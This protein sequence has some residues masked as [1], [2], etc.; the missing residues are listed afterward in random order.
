M[1]MKRILQALDGAATKPVAGSKDMKRFLEIV[2]SSPVKTESEPL[3]E[4]ANPHKVSLPVQ[5]AMQHYQSA[6]VKTEANKHIK[7]S[8]KKFFREVQAEAAETEFKEKEHKRQLLQQYSQQIA[9]RVLMKESATHNAKTYGEFTQTDWDNA[10]SVSLPYYGNNGWIGVGFRGDDAFVFGD[11]VQMGDYNAWITFIT[12]VQTGEMAYFKGYG[13]SWENGSVDYSEA[14]DAIREIVDDVIQH[15][16]STAEEIKNELNAGLTLDE[17]DDLGEA[18]TIKAKKKSDPC[19]SGY[20]QVGM[21]KK[22]NKMVPNCTKKNAVKETRIIHSDAKVDV[23]YK[24]HR[25]AVKSQLVGRMVPNKLLDRYINT[26]SAKYDVRP[27]DFEWHPS[28]DMG[29]SHSHQMADQFD[30]NVS[31]NPGF[32]PGPGGPGLMNENDTTGI[33]PTPPNNNA[34][35]LDHYKKMLTKFQE[36]RPAVE[37][38]VNEQHYEYEELEAQLY[39]LE[40]QLTESGIDVFASG[41]LTDKIKETVETVRLANAKAYAILTEMDYYIRQIQSN[42]EDLEYNDDDEGSL[43]LDIDEA[44]DNKKIT[45][46]NPVAH[47]AQTVAKG[48]GAHKNKKRQQE[49]P[50]K[51]KH[52]SSQMSEELNSI[53]MDPQ[54]ASYKKGN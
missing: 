31:P 23:Y 45:K 20:H 52:K 37:K 13:D 29:V 16:G 11:D 22:G 50:R 53:M 44:M 43:S 41:D 39:R 2:S 40:H 7:T 34:K 42:I 1:D 49:I 8:I 36:H 9:E 18:K 54:W 35:K 15:Y 21:K 6:P 5:M 4:G 26:L 32:K 25:G 28:H 27:E 10:Q 30:P 12:N 14:Q 51:E 46:R 47:A 19:W 38:L 24:P 33:M 3:T 48:S 17:P